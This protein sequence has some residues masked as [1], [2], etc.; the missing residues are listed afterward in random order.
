MPAAYP[1]PRRG[2]ILHKKRA[3]PPIAWG[4]RFVLILEGPPP[5]QDRAG[6][7]GQGLPMACQRRTLRRRAG[8]Q[9]CIKK[10]AATHYLGAAFLF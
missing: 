3:L 6:R 10:S 2:I 9:S 1:A 7:R 4:Q 5:R 8:G